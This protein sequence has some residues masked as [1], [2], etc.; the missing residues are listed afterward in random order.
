MLTTA[1][2][3]QDGQLFDEAIEITAPADLADAVSMR[4]ASFTPGLPTD[5][6]IEAPLVT[7]DDGQGTLGGGAAGTVR[8]ACQ[9]LANAND[10]DGNV[11]LVERGGCEF[12]VK[13]A[14]A[15]SAGAIAVVVYS[16]VGPPI[17]MNGD[18][19]SVGIPA[20]MIGTADGQVLVDR[21]AAD[22][23][24]GIAPGDDEH[25]AVSL[26]RGTFVTLSDEGN[27]LADFS[28]RG[29]SLSDA[30]FVKPDVTAP[31]VD[32]LAGQTPDVANGLRGETYQYLTGTSQAAPEVAGIAALLKEAH[33]DWSPGALKSALMTTAYTAVIREDGTWAD[34]F[35]MGAG[36]IDPNFAIDPGLVYDSDFRDHAAYLCGLREPPFSPTDCAD[37][38]AAG[39]PSAA[40][41]LNLPSIGLAEFISGDTVRRRVTNLG[42]PATFTAEVIP[43]PNVDVVVDPSSL[44]LGTGQTGDFTLRFT[45]RGTELDVW[46]FGEL[47]WHSDTH[48]VASPIALEA[49]TLRA[50]AELYLD[51]R[52]GT[53]QLPMAFGYQG[54]YSAGVHGL[55]KPSLDAD[56]ELPRGFVDDDPTNNFSFRF[57]NGVT[58]HG[59]TVPPNQLYLR[60]SLFDEFTDGNDDLDLFLFYCPNNQCTQIAE[61]GGL[62]SDEEINVILP[63]AGP[64]VVLVHGFETDQVAG[65]P[66]ANYSLFTWSFGL[67]DD[68]GNL[69]VTAP[70]SVAVGDRLDLDIDW[71]SLDPNMRYLGAVS[72]STPQGLYSLTIVNV[73][74]Q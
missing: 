34:A 10:I 23:E 27:I 51:G 37:L 64:Y 73:D 57:D 61:S 72:H 11:A 50:P 24:D 21:I 42:P 54:A 12:Q 17:V 16:N 56:G 28:S 66:G 46:N 26:K 62:T 43:P 47:A 74:A 53:S 25:V 59:I 7:A 3:T 40:V 35:D 55:R 9:P 33:P 60:V 69:G 49:V 6:P 68:V 4:E 32:I 20:V 71:A 70:T 8:D 14:N 48:R 39:Y 22:D 15:E 44:V 5:E 52:S 65:G 41:D 58:A 13:I 63:D 30:N 31:G 19:G 36:H 29:P 38:A 67:V 1:A 45:D 2:S 18:A